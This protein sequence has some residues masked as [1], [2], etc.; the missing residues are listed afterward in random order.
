MEIEVIDIQDADLELSYKSLVVPCK[1]DR[2]VF[3][4]RGS[5]VVVEVIHLIDGGGCSHVR[6]VCVEG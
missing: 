3:Q 4:D 5:L 1:G 6:V 2:L